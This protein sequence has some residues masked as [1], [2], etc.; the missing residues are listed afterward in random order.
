MSRRTQGIIEFSPD[1]DHII[2]Q[3]CGGQD[4]LDDDQSPSAWFGVPGPHAGRLIGCDGCGFWTHVQCYDVSDWQEGHDW[5]C[6]ACRSPPPSPPVC[7]Y[8]QRSSTLGGFRRGPQG[9]WVHV[10][11]ALWIH[12]W[13]T[14]DHCPNGARPCRT[15]HCGYCSVNG[16]KPFRDYPHQQRVESKYYRALRG[17]LFAGRCCLC[18]AKEG[19]KIPCCFGSASDRECPNVMHVSC[20]MERGPKAVRGSSSHDPRMLCPR[21]AAQPPWRLSVLGSMK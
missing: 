18:Q 2:C 3:I 19:C 14:G 5:Y 8:C 4:A 9:R 12:H 11:C 20:A 17:L 7:D 10:A 6:D 13:Y 15:R 21:H 1:S 16:L